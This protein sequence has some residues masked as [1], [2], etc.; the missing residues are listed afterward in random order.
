MAPNSS[1]PMPLPSPVTG[2]ATVCVDAAA[3]RATWTLCLCH[4]TKIT[5]GYIASHVSAPSAHA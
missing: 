2:V 1:M 3:K 4:F 5:G